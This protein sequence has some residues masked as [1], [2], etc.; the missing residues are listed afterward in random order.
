MRPNLCLCPDGQ[1]APSCLNKGTFL[2]PY[3]FTH[4][5][6]EV[7]ITS[8]ILNSPC[9]LCVQVFVLFSKGHLGSS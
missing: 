1:V 4:F 3:M 6:L 9:Y 2:V 5:N 7:P 8:C